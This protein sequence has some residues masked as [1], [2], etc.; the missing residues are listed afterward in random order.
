[1]GRKIP[2][3]LEK[4]LIKHNTDKTL[5]QVSKTAIANFVLPE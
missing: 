1:M 2:I 3:S 4:L 5:G